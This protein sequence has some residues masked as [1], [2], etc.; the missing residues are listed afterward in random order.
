MAKKLLW[1]AMARRRRLAREYRT[2]RGVRL[3]PLLAAYCDRAGIK[4]EKFA[5]GYQFRKDEYVINWHPGTNRIQVSYRLKHDGKTVA[6][7]SEEESTKPKILRVL[8]EL[9]SVVWT[10]A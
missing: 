3:V 2:R 9:S 10:W 1:V 7:E 6:V 5:H 8:E 4:M